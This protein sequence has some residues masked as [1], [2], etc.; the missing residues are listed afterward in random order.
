VNSKEHTIEAPALEGNERQLKIDKFID[1]IQDNLDTFTTDQFEQLRAT[2]KTKGFG[3]AQKDAKEVFGLKR[4]TIKIKAKERMKED[5]HEEIVDLKNIG[6]GLVEQTYE[7]QES[8]LRKVRIENPNDDQDESLNLDSQPRRAHEAVCTGF[9]SAPN[10]VFYLDS[11]D[12]GDQDDPKKPKNR[13]MATIRE[14]LMPEESQRAI[15]G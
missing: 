2:V 9:L 10:M 1:K 8:L 7:I 14:D 12:E 5:K 13:H 3:A 15:D 11:D 4:G 6:Q